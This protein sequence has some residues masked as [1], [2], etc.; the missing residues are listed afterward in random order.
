M[1]TMVLSDLLT[2]RLYLVQMLLTSIV[3]GVVIAWG[4]GNAYTTI[5][6]IVATNAFGIGFSL[7]ALDEHKGWDGFRVVLPLTRAQI[8]HGRYVSLLLVALYSTVVGCV[9]FGAVMAAAWLAP[10]ISVLS[11]LRAPFDL[12][13]FAVMCCA[14]LTVAFVTLAVSAPL[15]LYFGM[16]K[17]L[18]FLG[19]AM[20]LFFVVIT[21][22]FAQVDL[23]FADAVLASEN[24]SVVLFA[25][26]AGIALVLYALSAAIASVLYRKREF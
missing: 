25:G 3:V 10:G 4:M 8:V 19:M 24:G 1:K 13:L 7:L 21:I 18:R 17:A 6:C 2:V 23:S 12:G 9:V 16:T 15:S 11:A 22:A 20:V 5:P 26:I 14:G